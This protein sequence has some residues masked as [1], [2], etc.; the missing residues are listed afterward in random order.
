MY[1]TTVLEYLS[2][3]IDKGWTDE[4]EDKFQEQIRKQRRN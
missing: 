1:L 2:Y 4:E 3:T